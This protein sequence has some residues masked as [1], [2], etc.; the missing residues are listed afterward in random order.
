MKKKI[1]ILDDHE[2]PRIL[3]SSTNVSFDKGYQIANVLSPQMLATQNNY[4]QMNNY[5]SSPL[6]IKTPVP[7][8]RPM[9]KV[10]RSPSNLNEVVYKLNYPKKQYEPLIINHKH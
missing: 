5:F 4:M 7:K 10:G 8:S 3:P 2:P 1:R 9:S 6:N